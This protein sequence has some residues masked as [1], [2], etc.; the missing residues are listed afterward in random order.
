M[1]VKDNIKSIK[2][3]DKKL[4][5]KEKAFKKILKAKY[6]DLGKEAKKQVKAL[7][8]TT[9]TSRKKINV[10]K[11][12]ANKDLTKNINTKLEKYFTDIEK[13]AKK[14]VR[15]ELMKHAKTKEEKIKV[16][17]ISA[18]QASKGN[19]AWAKKLA[20][21]QTADF[22]KYI[23]D[24]IKKA[25]AI[26]KEN[27]LKLSEKDI[28]KII[29]QKTDSFIN[30]RLDNTVENEANRIQNQVRAEAYKETGMVKGIVF[31][32]VLDD[33]TTANC[34]SKNGTKIAIDDPMLQQYLIPQHPRCRSYH[35]YILMTDRTKMSSR[36]TILL[37][38]RSKDM[39]KPPKDQP[40]Y[41]AFNGF[42]F[43][44]FSK[45]A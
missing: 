32:A 40:K 36:S 28:K 6:E 41:Y 31:T 3:L 39:P 7:E 1:S 37:R 29:N 35:V 5:T 13:E 16:A 45:V 15:S 27:D 4:K 43:Y 38:G 17:N 8:S 34:R 20:K 18:K 11:K 25:K 44:E 24:S 10:A 14:S 19:K 42:I 22:D 23:N 30:T 9:A 12:K 2:K 33:R 26:A 21:K